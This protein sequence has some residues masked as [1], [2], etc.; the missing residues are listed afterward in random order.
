MVHRIL[1]RYHILTAFDTQ[2]V[3]FTNFTLERLYTFSHSKAGHLE[4]LLTEMA[5]AAAIDHFYAGNH[6]G[7]L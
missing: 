6:A 3:G 7:P 4:M 2:L 1:C 5:A